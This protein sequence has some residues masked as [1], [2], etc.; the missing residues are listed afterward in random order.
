M[1]EVV[2]DEK[3]ERNTARRRHEKESCGACVLLVLIA[4]PYNDD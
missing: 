2:R 3:Q 1:E 4:I